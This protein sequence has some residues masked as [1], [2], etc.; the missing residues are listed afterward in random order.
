MKLS[1][2]KDYFQE[3]KEEFPNLSNMELLEIIKVM[4]LYDIR[5][6]L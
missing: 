4:V 1:T 6:K 5:Q 2:L 3:V